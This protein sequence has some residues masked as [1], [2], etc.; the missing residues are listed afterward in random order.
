MTGE[1]ASLTGTA[2]TE[3]DAVERVNPTGAGPLLLICEH[4]SKRIPEVYGTL[5]LS[6][7][8]LDSHIA[9]DPGARKV[10]LM[11]SEAF[12]SPL[13]ASRVSRLIYDCNR[14]PENPG[15]MPE[16]SEIYDIPGNANLS[17]TERRKRELAVY[18]PF[19]AAIRETIEARTARGLSTL[20]V[21]IHSFTPIYHGKPRAVEFG[22]IHDT[23]SRAAD[24][25]L[26]RAKAMT[27]RR[28]SRNEPYSAADGVAHTLQV[29]GT[30]GGLANVMIE[31]RNDLLTDEAG[32]AM[33]AD[34][35][36]ALLESAVERLGAPKA[37]AAHA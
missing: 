12:A 11:L 7:E 18:R 4:A 35:I 29:F 19:Q 3:P 16:R 33:I 36:Q 8:A 9:W 28:V 14:P 32:I 26:A 24:A 13:I 1:A 21:T 22:I 34:E 5:G 30:A 2:E 20:L 25:I 27:H 23:D 15:A 31:I 10:A 6:A 17:D 37:E